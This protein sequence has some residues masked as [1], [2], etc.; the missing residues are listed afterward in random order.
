[1]KV[2]QALIRSH[3]QQV[4]RRGEWA[5]IAGVVLVQP[6]GEDMRIC[7]HVVFPDGA[8]DYWGIHGNHEIRPIFQKTVTA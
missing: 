2:Y 1:M 3:E 8:S 5:A 7:V 4:L 6:E